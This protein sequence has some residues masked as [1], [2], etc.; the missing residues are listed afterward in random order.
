M[1]NEFSQLFRRQRRPLAWQ[2]HKVGCRERKTSQITCYKWEMPPLA[3]S[4][5]VCSA[6]T[7]FSSWHVDAYLKL[8]ERS[9]AIQLE[10]EPLKKPLKISRV[11]ALLCETHFV[12]NPQKVA[13]WVSWDI[14][15]DMDFKSCGNLSSGRW[16]E[17]KTSF[18]WQTSTYFR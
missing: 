7:A 16:V 2:P 4:L 12:F 11:L 10:G 8:R 6:N 14:Y 3:R 17:K 1:T 15:E 9:L 13:H 5:C 18:L